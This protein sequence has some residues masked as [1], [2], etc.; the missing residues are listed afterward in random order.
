MKTGN[1]TAMCPRLT[2]FS[3]GTDNPPDAKVKEPTDGRVPAE[4][5]EDEP[6]QKILTKRE[7]R[8]IQHL[9]QQRLQSL[10]HKENETRSTYPMDLWYILSN[11][12]CPTQVQTFAQ[13][14]QGAY[15]ATNSVK[16]WLNLYKRFVLEH[17][18]LPN[19]LRPNEINVKS[20]LRAR[21]IRA[22]FHVH[23]PLVKTVVHNVPCTD[24]PG[25]AELR[26]CVLSWWKPMTSSK[27][28]VNV[29]LYY[30]KL[31][32]NENFKP[33]NIM[34]ARNLMKFNTEEDCVLLRVAVS[35]FTPIRAVQGLVLTSISVSVS[36][37]MRF[38]RLKLVFHERRHNK[39]YEKHQGQV[40]ILDPIL[41]L[42]IL[43]WW[44]PQYPHPLDH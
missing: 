23:P 37:D 9:D 44:D 20:G 42:Q 36:R 26:Y 5:V 27:S 19:H 41:D 13:I 12:I 30:F 3:I 18:M 8:R 35:S 16:F 43:H 21:V 31:T 40:I 24:A 14:C 33:K 29:W 22:L 39:R 1:R 7:K 28:N 17:K 2:T 38:H 4:T 25:H 10:Y 15:Q 11:F 6:T 34:E 32:S